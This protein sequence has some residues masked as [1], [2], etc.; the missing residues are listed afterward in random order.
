MTRRGGRGPKGRV[1]HHS[2]KTSM[3]AQMRGEVKY[4]DGAIR[5]ACQHVGAT[6]GDDKL[7]VVLG[8]GDLDVQDR[9]SER[10][11]V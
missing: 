2:V 7:G 6:R 11:K 1:D 5:L 3:Q 10:S 8:V 4:P 9:E